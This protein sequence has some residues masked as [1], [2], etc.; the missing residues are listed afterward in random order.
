MSTK[1]LLS[2]KEVLKKL[3]KEE[4]D[5]KKNKK[6][7]RDAWT[8]VAIIAVVML[9]AVGLSFYKTSTMEIKEY[10]GKSLAK[11][12]EKREN[13]KNVIMGLGVVC[14]GV[15][16]IALVNRSKNKTE[17]ISPEEMHRAEQRKL[18]A[19]R[20]RV[21]EARRNRLSEEATVTMTRSNRESMHSHSDIHRGG[22]GER[23]NMSMMDMEDRETY[24]ERRK[25][26]YQYYM[27][28]D[29]EDGEEVDDEKIS[30]SGKSGRSYRDNKKKKIII[31]IAIGVIALVITLI[32]VL[33]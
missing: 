4:R 6:A 33:L 15:L 24:L 27:E 11:E 32:I 25:R 28:N 7:R 29:L 14:T 2:E 18:D 12:H 8:A 21:E 1:E 30:S 31:G 22:I 20:E 13:T 17:T 19:A 3:A 23:G 16:V 10:S 26:E 9:I 5:K